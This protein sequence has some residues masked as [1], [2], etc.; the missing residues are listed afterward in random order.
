MHN[1]LRGS[2]A[3]SLIIFGGTIWQRKEN[4]AAVVKAVQVK[5]RQYNA[6]NVAELY[7]LIKQKSIPREFQPLNLNWQEN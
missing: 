5:V 7:L 2:R 6:P 1:V 3:A 4:L